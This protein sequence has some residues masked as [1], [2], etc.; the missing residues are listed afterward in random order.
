MTS[1][2]TGRA[3]QSVPD[4]GRLSR[5]FVRPDDPSGR[6]RPEIQA[7]RAIAVVSVVI[8][9]FWPAR[10]PG[11]YVGV[12][13]FFVISGYLIIGHLLREAHTSGRIRLV[14]FWAR[15]A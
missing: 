2:L 8:Y 12:D 13:V 3:A 6:V 7:L 10:L 15:R 5:F 11:G 1:T 4:Q 14:D 9:H